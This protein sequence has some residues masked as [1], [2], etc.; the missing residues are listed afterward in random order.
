MKQAHLDRMMQSRDKRFHRIAMKMGYQR[1]DMVAEP[2]RS[3]DELAELRAEYTEKVGRKPYH[4][5]DADEL[6]QKIAEA[7]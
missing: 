2:I 5:W 6:R 3:T 1:R 4:G 7:E